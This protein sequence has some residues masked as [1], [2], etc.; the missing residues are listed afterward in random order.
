VKS[1]IPDDFMPAEALRNANLRAPGG[2]WKT[3]ENTGALRRVSLALGS[4]AVLSDSDAEG[5]PDIVA[6]SPHSLARTGDGPDSSAARPSRQPG[7]A[8][9]ASAAA[10]AQ[11]AAGLDASGAV[12]VDVDSDGL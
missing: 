2:R 9:P 11:G 3:L 8:A 5:A 4:S 10:S 12:V 1:H 7:R 6:P